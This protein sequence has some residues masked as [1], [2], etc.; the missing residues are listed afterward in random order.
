MYRTYAEQMTTAE[1]AVGRK[2]VIAEMCRMFGFSTAKAYKVLKE[3]GWDSGRAKR[4][5]AGVSSVDKELLTA[6]GEM[7]KQGIR[8][9]GKATLPVNVARS[10]LEARGLDIPVGDSRLRE[11]LRENHLS[12][13]DSKVPTPH[14]NMRTEYPNQVHFADPSV[15]LIYFAPGGKQKIIGDDEL[16]KNKNFLEGKMK[17]WRYVLTDHYSGCL[18]VRYYAAMGETAAN[19]Y[20]FLLYA[21][22]QKNNNVNVFHGIPE[23]LIWDCGTANIARA[24]TNALKAFGVKTLPHLPGN[25]RAKGQVENGNNL[26]ETQFESRLRFEPVNSIEELNDAAGRF[27]SAYNANLINGLD[28]RLRRG[29]VIIGSRANLW[30]RI[31]VE[32]LRE[33][34]DEE[35]CRQVFANGVQTRK[36]AGDLTVSIVHP[37][38]GRSLR[39]SVRDLPEILVG[40]ELKLQP[41]LISVEP[42]CIASYETKGKEMS[43]ELEPIVFDDAGFDIN[44]PV[45]GQEYK[46]PKDTERETA[47]KI[48]E[49]PG[50]AAVMGPAHSFIKPENPFMRNSAGMP[51]DVAETV[52]THEIIISAV[53]AA[54]RVKA[55]CGE[56]PEGFINTLREQYPE[57]VP[58]RVVDDFIKARKPRIEVPIN[59]KD[60]VIHGSAA[61]LAGEN[62]EIPVAAKKSKIA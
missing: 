50:L 40:M 41:L 35:T 23:L 19:M 13:A 20:D 2:A 48:L 51:I 32:K 26:I 44:S 12:V 45:F 9:N 3:S 31:P 53:E 30:Q 5:D 21:W 42:L 11:L 61:A 57:G 10:I 47:G 7:V 60:W 39:Y 22:G 59:T 54:K 14:Q 28:T 1:T 62:K 46:R 29:G 8:K 17:C 34:P 16:Y 4:K 27:Y 49:K 15:C 43:F 6:V 37:R 52:H 24:T 58:T 56:V 25:P 36:V 33:L 18:C 55:Q 38:A